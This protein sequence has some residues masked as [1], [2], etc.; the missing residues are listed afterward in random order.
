M[1]RLVVSVFQLNGT[2]L[3]AGD[4]ITTPFGLTSARWQVLGALEVGQ[5]ALT[6][7]Q[8]AK[9]MGLSRQA[10]LKQITLLA[11]DGLVQSQANQAHKRSELWSL[12]PTGH[13]QF[14]SIMAAQRRQV[15]QWRKG[16]TLAELVECTRVLETLTRSIQQAAEAPETVRPHSPFHTDKRKARQ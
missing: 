15:A 10:V 5:G 7:P 14:E 16:L 2:L 11:S 13:V 9:S 6:I 1:D 12:T 8:I 4:R 3:E